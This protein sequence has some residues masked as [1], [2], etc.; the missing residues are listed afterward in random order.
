MLKVKK[1]CDLSDYIKRGILD[2]EYYGYIIDEHYFHILIR[3]LKK[4][5][6]SASQMEIDKIYNIIEDYSIR[7]L[8]GN[9]PTFLSGSFDNIFQII[10]E[11]PSKYKMLMNKNFYKAI[12]DKNIN[13]AQTFILNA[14]GY[15]PVIDVGGEIIC[16]DMNRIYICGETPDTNFLKNWDFNDSSFRD[17]QWNNG[18]N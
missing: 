13:A 15:G 12:K 14:Y 4:A 16:Y 3:F 1:Y 7:E 2:D 5:F 18:Y 17:N 10:D 11:L 9:L 8:S 6:P